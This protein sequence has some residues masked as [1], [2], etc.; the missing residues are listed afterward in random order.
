MRLWSTFD[1]WLLV[2]GLTED[3]SH[4]ET[5]FIVVESLGEN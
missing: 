4:F 1:M 3:F 2:R 5:G